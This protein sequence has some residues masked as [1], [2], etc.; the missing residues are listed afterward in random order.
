MYQLRATHQEYH[1][2]KPGQSSEVANLIKS[3]SDGAIKIDPNNHYAELWMGAHVK[4]PSKL[5][6]NGQETSSLR[7]LCPNLPYLLKV[8]S[9]DT[10]LS[11]QA[12]PN[13][14]HAEEL[15]SK[16]PDVYKDPN[17]KPEMCVA[18]TKFEGLCG[19]RNFSEISNFL[20]KVPGL[21]SVCKCSAKKISS[22]EELK[23]AFSNL[24]TADSEDVKAALESAVAEVKIDNNDLLGDLLHKLNSQYPNDV[25]V[26]CIYFL[27]RVVLNPGECMFLSA[28]VPHAYLNGNCVECMACS[29]NVVR[30]G[31]TPKLRD[32][33]VLIKMLEYKPS[34][35]DERKFQPKVD[36]LGAENSK[37]YKIS[38][39]STPIEDFL[40]R[41]ISTENGGQGVLENVPESEAI[42]LCSSG[43]CE[44]EV[45]FQE[46]SN[47]NA[48]HGFE[49]FDQISKIQV[50]SVGFVPRNSGNLTIKNGSHDLVL[51]RATKNVC[52]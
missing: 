1:W 13:K 29:D 17:H 20:E 6:E 10:A 45:E 47:T 46:N 14:T 25:G 30:A 11:I 43:S 26:Y 31:L 19:F 50:G 34:S 51:W 21:S 22:E 41:Q 16:R 49:K 27:N 38:T 33:E 23:Y 15:H 32:V 35:A 28:N 9:V 3:N 2:G 48:K 5:T 40:V 18:L 24:M 52:F 44:I 7:D 4:S 42:Y 39:F 8:L 36:F 12:H 37:S